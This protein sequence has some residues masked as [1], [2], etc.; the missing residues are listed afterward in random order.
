MNLTLPVRP[1]RVFRLVLSL[2]AIAT[3][4]T[5]LLFVGGANAL[6]PW[7]GLQPALLRAT[8]WS[9]VLFGML[10]GWAARRASTPWAAFAAI[11]AGNAAYVAESLAVLALGWI[12]PTGLGTAA[13]IGLAAVVAVLAALE[14]AGLRRSSVLAA[15]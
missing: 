2:D 3:A 13:V 1:D 10:I 15:A 7:L 4:A 8:G 9:F 14:A 11:V 6:E 12:V 5:G